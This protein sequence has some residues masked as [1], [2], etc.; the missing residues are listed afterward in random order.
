MSRVVSRVVKNRRG[1]PGKFCRRTY[2]RERTRMVQCLT[3]SRGSTKNTCHPCGRRGHMRETTYHFFFLAGSKFSHCTKNMTRDKFCLLHLILDT[4][5][6]PRPNPLVTATMVSRFAKK[7]KCRV[8][9]V[10]AV[11]LTLGFGS[12][13]AYNTSLHQQ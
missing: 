12:N 3:W 13:S 8:G 6:E 2:R 4:E 10:W 1:D 9:L 5:F 7:N 11:F